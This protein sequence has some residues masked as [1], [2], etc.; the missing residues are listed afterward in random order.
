MEELFKNYKRPRAEINEIEKFIKLF[1][2]SQCLYKNK[3]Y[4]KALEELKK[5]YHLLIDIWDEFPKI[6]TLYLIM[7]S[8]FHL[9]QYTKCLSI[10][11]DISEKILIEKR[12]DKGKKHKNK[13]KYDLF[14]KIKA[15]MEMYKILIYFIYDDLDNSIDSL[16]IIIRKQ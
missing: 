3:E 13:D 12:R 2:T 8:Y 15:K 14:I 11:K 6:K 7:K 4:Q 1:K 16:K 10:Q 5:S 9:K